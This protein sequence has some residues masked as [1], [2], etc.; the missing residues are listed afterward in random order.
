MKLDAPRKSAYA[1]RSEYERILEEIKCCDSI[2]AADILQQ[3]ESAVIKTFPE[4]WEET[5][6]MEFNHKR[7]T[8]KD[9]RQEKDYASA[10]ADRQL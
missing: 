6:G 9:A 10:R 4:S 3:N 5:I 8:L 1:S 2:D 7:N